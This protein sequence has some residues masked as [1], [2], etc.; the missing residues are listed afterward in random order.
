M[1]TWTE[2]S[3]NPF[4]QSLLGMRNQETPFFEESDA[5]NVSKIGHFNQV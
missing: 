2:A 3:A 4:I 1:K 5:Q